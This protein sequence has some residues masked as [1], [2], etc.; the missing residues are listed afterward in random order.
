[1]GSI[2]NYEPRSDYIG[3]GNTSAYS[4]NFKIHNK[5]NILVVKFDDQGNEVWKVKGD[6]NS[7]LLNVSINPDSQVGGTV[8]LQTNLEMDY[9]L[10]IIQAA[11]NPIFSKDYSK[12][13]YWD[14][15]QFQA[16]FEQLT[17]QL[18]SVAYLAHRS[19]KL[20]DNVA[21]IDANNF[22]NDLEILPDAVIAFNPTADGFTTLPRGSFIGPPGPQGDPGTNGTPGAPGTNGLGILRS[23][24]INLVQGQKT[25]SIIF[26]S[27]TVDTN[28]V[29]HASTIICDDT[30]PRKLEGTVKNLTTN[31]FDV[32]FNVA[33]DTAN[34]QL[35]WSIQDAI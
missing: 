11:N 12:S 17:V 9:V 31:G 1:M 35:A 33:P 3:T 4:F 10:S 27:A 20:G 15:K 13:T 7:V 28:Y 23:G 5:S 21:Q 30:Y 22:N 34:Y 29:P 2:P 18:Q 6:D 14:L 19:P 16:S 8:V 32:E 25:I 24:R 26:S